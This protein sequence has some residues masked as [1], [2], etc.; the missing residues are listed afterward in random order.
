MGKTELV[1]GKHVQEPFCLPLIPTWSGLVANPCLRGGA[2]NIMLKA[3]CCLCRT[4]IRSSRICNVSNSFWGIG[5]HIFVCSSP[6][7]SDFHFFFG[8]P[9]KCWDN[10]VP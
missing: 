7:V 2:V 1:G 5:I 3:M 4:A 9:R 10:I 6:A 8:S